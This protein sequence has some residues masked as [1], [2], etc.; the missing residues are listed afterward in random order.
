MIFRFVKRYSHLFML[1]Y[2][3]KLIIEFA[4]IHCTGTE[5]PV[6]MEIFI[7]TSSPARNSADRKNRS[8]H[9]RRYPR[10]L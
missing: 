5:Y 9:I 1:I 7:N 10:Q 6:I 4:G 3:K 8:E 2:W